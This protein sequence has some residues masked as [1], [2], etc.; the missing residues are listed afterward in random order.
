MTKENLSYSNIIIRVLAY[1]C[2]TLFPV[3]GDNKMGKL[4]K[5][6][7]MLDTC[8]TVVGHV[9]DRGFGKQKWPGRPHVGHCSHRHALLHN[10]WGGQI[11]TCISLLSDSDRSEIKFRSIPGGF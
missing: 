2:W 4:D 1:E 11:E 7:A 6:V 9:L 5:K 8:W 10:I 3:F